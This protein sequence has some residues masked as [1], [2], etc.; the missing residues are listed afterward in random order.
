MNNISKTFI[1]L[2]RDKLLQKI[3]R[4][5][6][7]NGIGLIATKILMFGAMILF[8]RSLSETEFGIWG[9]LYGML[10]SLLMFVDGP[11]SAAVTKYVADYRDTDKD[12]VG[13]LIAFYLLIMLLIAIV[14][15]ILAFGFPKQIAG[16][17]NHKELYRP[18]SIIL[19]S[20]IPLGILSI[21]KGVINGLEEFKM[22][23]L[24]FPTLTIIDV[25]VKCCGLWINGFNG[26]IV[27]TL[28]ATSCQSLIGSIFFSVALKRHKISLILHGCFNM[29]NKLLTF[30]LPNLIYIIIT[31]FGNLV[32]PSFFISVPGGSE[33]LA[34]YSTMTQLQSVLS[35]LPLMMAAPLLAILSRAFNE[36]PNKAQKTFLRLTGLLVFLLLT[37]GI[38][39]ILS[40]K[41]LMGLY[42]DFYV[43]SAGLFRLFIPAMICQILCPFFNQLFVAL[44]KLWLMNLGRIVWLLVYISCG[45]FLR[46]EG[47]RGIVWAT[48]AGSFCWLISHVFSMI[49]VY[50]KMSAS[51]K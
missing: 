11:W 30:T 40:A 34:N 51:L 16:M 33:T 2:Y 27:A 47:L 12:K 39:F 6:F 38:I 22:C 31:C 14:I 43:K 35:F 8:A 32:V 42:G 41:Y 18:I 13:Q 50:K 37:L 45:W 49:Y 46:E 26:L 29:S 1:I 15:M 24:L 4:G 5:G 3:F 19:L 28:V 23:S 48:L 10:L 36:N 9:Y 17:I 25:A 7:W 44:E 20:L 21:L